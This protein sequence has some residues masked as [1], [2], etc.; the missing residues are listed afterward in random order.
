MAL[1]PEVLPRV[2]EHVRDALLLRVRQLAPRHRIL[3][4]RIDG[5]EVDAAIQRERAVKF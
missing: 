5:V 2:G 1:R 3:Q 4:R